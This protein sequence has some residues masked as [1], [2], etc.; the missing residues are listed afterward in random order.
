MNHD[1]SVEATIAPLAASNAVA[2]EANRLPPNIQSVGILLVKPMKTFRAD[3][4]E[5]TAVPQV[6][7]VGTAGQLPP[8]FSGECYWIWPR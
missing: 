8:I 5:G 3:E 4:D 2:M 7:D 6:R 1:R